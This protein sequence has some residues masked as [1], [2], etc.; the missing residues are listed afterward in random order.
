MSQ[1]RPSKTVTISLP[2]NLA[3]QI[4]RV[5]AAENRSRSEL[6]REVFRQY[7]ERRRRWDQIFA[8]GS[9]RAKATGLTSEDQ[10]SRAVK[11][12]RRR[13]AG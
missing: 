6:V 5:A 4:D 7:L 1:A 10:V 12:H 9:R 2:R 3:A 13:K 8:Y 11:E